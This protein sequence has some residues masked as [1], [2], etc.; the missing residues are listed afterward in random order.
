MLRNSEMV[1]RPMIADSLGLSKM[2]VSRLVRD[3]MSEGICIAIGGENSS[4]SLGRRPDVISMNPKY[5][6]V[7][8]CL[9]A[10]SKTI[11]ISDITGAT[12]LKKSIPE[13]AC[14]RPDD[15]ITF[16]DKTVRNFARDQKQLSKIIGV[17]RCCCRKI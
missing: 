12:L 13:D 6:F 15:A 2:S 3:L 4:K 16:I 17:L 11:T 7:A 9:S 5:G 8:I 10:F 1:S 14:Q